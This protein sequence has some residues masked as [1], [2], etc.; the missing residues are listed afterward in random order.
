VDGFMASTFLR[1][2]RIDRRRSFV[3]PIGAERMPLIPISHASFMLMSSAA[4]YSRSSV[5]TVSFIALF[6][7]AKLETR[8]G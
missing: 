1:L 6:A 3:R 5:A 4:G 2:E 8:T 7:L